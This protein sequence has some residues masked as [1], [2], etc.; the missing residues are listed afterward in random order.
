MIN[1]AKQITQ[2]TGKLNYYMNKSN[3]NLNQESQINDYKFELKSD[4]T[5]LYETQQEFMNFILHSADIGHAAKP[6]NLEVKWSNLVFEEFFHQ[7][8]LEKSMSLPSSYL[9]NRDSNLA[10]F[11]ISFINKIVYPNF[12][13]L[14]QMSSEL[15]K[16]MEYIEENLE[17]WKIKS[18]EK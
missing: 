9:F 13:L 17:K 3:N 2:I 7:G 8:D 14:I 5:D 6:F 1:H 12:E 4:D 11:Q 16:Y 18:E 10:K 15:E